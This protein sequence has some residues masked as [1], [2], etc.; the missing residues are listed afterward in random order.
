MLGVFK[1][2]DEDNKLSKTFYSKKTIIDS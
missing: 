1:I 2:E